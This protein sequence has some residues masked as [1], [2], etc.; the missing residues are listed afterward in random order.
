MPWRFLEVRDYKDVNTSGPTYD[1]DFPADFIDVFKMD[2]ATDGEARWTNLNAAVPDTIFN[3][4]E[5][6]GAPVAQVNPTLAVITTFG[7]ST[8]QPKGPISCRYVNG[9][10]PLLVDSTAFVSGPVWGWGTGL[11]FDA[12][13][14]EALDETGAVIASTTVGALPVVDEPRAVTYTGFSWVD[15]PRYTGP[16]YGF[17]LTH[18][19]ETSG[20]PQVLSIGGVFIE[21]RNTG[22][23]KYLRQRQS[24]RGNPTRQVQGI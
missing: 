6:T 7:L 4:R 20:D 18:Y 11:D 21:Y 14:F 12:C 15:V 16:H 2:F 23:A 10:Q 24:P 9:G 13:T 5:L 8:T 1:T 17:R 19:D 22:E 3:A